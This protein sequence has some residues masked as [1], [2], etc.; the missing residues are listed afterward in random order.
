[1]ALGVAVW[2]MCFSF[3]SSFHKEVL[4]LLRAVK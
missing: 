4:T 2:E 3:W 1:M